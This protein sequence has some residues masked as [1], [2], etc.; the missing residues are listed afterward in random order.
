MP[1]SSILRPPVTAKQR[2]MKIPGDQPEKVLIDG[3]WGKVT[4][5]RVF[6]FFLASARS[7]LVWEDTEQGWPPGRQKCDSNVQRQ[8][9]SRWAGWSVR[10][11]WSIFVNPNHKVYGQMKTK[12]YDLQLNRVSKRSQTCACRLKTK[13]TELS[14]AP[15]SRRVVRERRS[16]YLTLPY[17][18]YYKVFV[19]FEYWKF[20]STEGYRSPNLKP[21]GRLPMRFR[22]LRFSSG[23]GLMPIAGWLLK[24]WR[25]T[26]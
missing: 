14:D 3:Y 13:E 21:Y 1:H 26:T 23:N 4:H 15:V 20:A 25:S 18:F 9:S 19:L 11:S 24:N 8:R 17:L 5:Y 16:L 2:V 6:A 7:Y 12:Y 10:L 22:F